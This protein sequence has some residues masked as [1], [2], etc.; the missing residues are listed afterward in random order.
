ML[1]ILAWIVFGG[2]AGWLASMIMRTNENQGM[3]EHYCW[4]LGR[5]ARRLVG[6]GLWRQRPAGLQRLQLPRRRF[7]RGGAAGYRQLLPPW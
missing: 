3:L 5:G 6:S 4:Y 2:I 7:G 1:D